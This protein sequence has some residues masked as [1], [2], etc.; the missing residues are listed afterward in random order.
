MAARA[1]K[2][3]HIGR[4]GNFHPLSKARLLGSF[5]QAVSMVAF[6]MRTDSCSDCC[7][8]G[9][10]YFRCILQQGLVKGEGTMEPE[11]DDLKH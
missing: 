10:F 7:F 5:E 11:I 2:S 8:S 4:S 1:S 9:A 6:I 3:M